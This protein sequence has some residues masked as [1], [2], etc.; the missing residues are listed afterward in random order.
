MP[1]CQPDTPRPPT[2]L[3]HAQ[4]TNALVPTQERGNETKNAPAWRLAGLEP[5]DP[6]GTSEA[7]QRTLS[8][9]SAL[10]PVSG[11]LGSGP[12]APHVP[13]LFLQRSCGI[14]LRYGRR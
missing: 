7:C 2:D 11:S 1:R 14:L 13:Q 12:S 8:A 6:S 9:L 4:S 10:H 3:A 5:G